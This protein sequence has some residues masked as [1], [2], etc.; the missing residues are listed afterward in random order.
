[1]RPYDAGRLGRAE[2]L[3]P[4]VGITLVAL[5]LQGL[6]EVD[7]GGGVQV[8]PWNIAIV[9]G[10]VLAG[11]YLTRGQPL[12]WV[13]GP[14]MVPVLAYGV[15]GGWMLLTV[16]WSSQALVSLATA[17]AQIGNVLV[18]TA[19]VTATLNDRSVDRL[20]SMVFYIGA[21]IAVV[22]LGLFLPV[23]ARYPALPG[24]AGLGWIFD[25]G[26]AL[27]LQGFASDPN[28]FTMYLSLSLFCGLAGG[29]IA[30]RFPGLVAIGI[31]L[32]L[33]MSRSI[34]LAV[35][36]VLVATPLIL[37]IRD[38]YVMRWYV[39]R[40]APVLAVLG[41]AA[42]SAIVAV[43]P[44]RQFVIARIGSVA[45]QSR[46]R[47]WG[48]A[49]DLGGN[50]FVGLG[51]RSVDESL[52]HFSHN[53]YLDVFIELGVVGG[54]LWLVFVLGVAL[55]GVRYCTGRRSVAWLQGWLAL[56]LASSTFSWLYNPLFAVVAGVVIA[57]ARREMAASRAGFR[58][59]MRRSSPV[60]SAPSV[61]RRIPRT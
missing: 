50:P 24:K 5:H 25:R 21:L 43:A 59:P 13:Q 51:L 47:K 54:V 9:I 56:V 53:T 45:Q 8:A 57:V 11:L 55:V 22:S 31:A 52:G 39:R 34:G 27:R 29:S 3:L 44:I 16:L 17:V 49:L 10:V 42:V 37:A 61:L 60:A 14:P 58:G 1:M 41:V 28:F 6:L 4:L 20:N 35:V 18:F 36:L 12:E 30:K 40:T 2:L 23:L 33:A 26:L 7:I 32:F 38:R 15:L 48:E 46:I 19:L